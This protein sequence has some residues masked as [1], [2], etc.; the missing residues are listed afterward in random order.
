VK[1]PQAFRQ[2][3]V[4]KVALVTFSGACL[5]LVLWVMNAAR[6]LRPSVDDYCIAARAGQGVIGGFV[7]DWQTYSGFVTP[8]FLTNAL[9]GVPLVRLPL[10]AASAV[11]FMLG[12]L[13]MTLFVLVLATRSMTREPKV[14]RLLIA[15]TVAPIAAVS[16]WA[17]LW[18]SYTASGQAAPQDVALAVT[19]WQNI[20][21]AYVIPVALIAALGLVLYGRTFN[22]GWVA[23][24]CGAL[25]G[26]ASG[27]MGPTFA[28]AVVVF[29][30]GL[31]LTL[32]LTAPE[33]ARR[34]LARIVSVCLFTAIGL[35]VS[36]AS[37]GTHLR[38]D[39][40][41]GVSVGVNSESLP[42]WIIRVFPDTYQAWGQAFIHWGTVLVL[43]VS[44]ALGS[45]AI[46]SG[47]KFRREVVAP[48]TVALLG[49]SL[50]L[51]GATLVGD[52]VAY[53][54]YWHQTS[55]QVVVFGATVSMGLW[56]ATEARN[57]AATWWTA[58]ILI[59]VATGL[60]C[61]TGAVIDMTSSIVEREQRWS[62]GPAPVGDA[63]DD[64]ELWGLDQCWQ[65]VL[66]LRE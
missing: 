5:L 32:W 27:L 60:T 18:T 61:Y 53:G 31:V 59:V 54:A 48:Q 21:T 22:R 40:N 9:V 19:H 33:E 47:L 66:T 20:N 4:A 10:W 46:H 42:A 45:L 13:A 1:G 14:R 63:I 34:V 3:R 65:E 36:F 35:G 37:P 6:Y 39:N 55:V 64:R 51:A 62:V 50:I 17:F 30:V 57:L 11:P 28:L 2:V 44:V 56:V 52:T 26:L 43:V 23:V 25:L 41:F 7:Q 58:L 24:A 38:M 8:S 49:L 29:A 15:L 12:A 16:W